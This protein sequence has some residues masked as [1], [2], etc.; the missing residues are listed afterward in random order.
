M[1]GYISF[2]LMPVTVC[3]VYQLRLTL[4]LEL[5]FSR[6]FKVA[7]SKLSFS[8]LIVVLSSPL[9]RDLSTIRHH[10]LKLKIKR[11]KGLH[12]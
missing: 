10:I 4:S 5:Y 1:S 9:D 3:F 6:I 8:S 2:S 7:I 12:I 11:S